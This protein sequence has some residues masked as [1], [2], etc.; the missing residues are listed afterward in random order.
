MSRAGVGFDK[1]TLSDGILLG[2]ARCQSI[3]P[4]DKDAD[5][6]VHS[7]SIMKLASLLPDVKADK[8]ASNLV[9]G[10]FLF[11]ISRRRCNQ[12]EPRTLSGLIIM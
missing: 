10:R 9:D 2:Q 11:F 1:W 6:C 12:H 8:P 4:W 5:I 3:L 7:D